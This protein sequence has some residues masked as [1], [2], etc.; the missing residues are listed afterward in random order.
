[1]WPPSSDPIAHG[2]PGSSGPAVVVLFD[3][4]RLVRP[5]GWI[6]GRYKTSKPS[7]AMSGTSA[8]TSRSVPCRSGIGGGRAR[9]QLVPGAVARP[10]PGRDEGE[11]VGGRGAAAPVRVRGH[12]GVQLRGDGERAASAARGGGASR[13]PLQTVGVVGGA[14]GACAPRGVADEPRPLLQ[15]HGHVLAGREPLLEVGAPRRPRVDPALHAEP[16]GPC[17]RI[18]TSERQWSFPRGTI[19]VSRVSASP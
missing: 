14:R 8:A 4:L 7:S 15:L 2:L 3:P 5:I 1:M 9:E 6:G 11:L 12:Q 18:G 17:S 19:G 10:L 16:I 13:P